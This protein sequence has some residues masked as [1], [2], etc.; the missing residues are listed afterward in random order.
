MHD[1]AWHH[2][3]GFGDSD[4]RSR[5]PGGIDR[6]RYPTPAVK[7]IADVLTA[8]FEDHDARPAIEIP[9]SAL[10]CTYGELAEG[11]ARWSAVEG[12]GERPLLVQL[13]KTM[14]YYEL[15][16]GAFLHGWSFCPLDVTYPLQRVQHIAGQLG[17]PLVIAGDPQRAAEMRAA[18]FDVVGPEARPARAPTVIPPATAPPRYYIATSGTTGVP[19]LV[20]VDHDATRP[21]LDWAL[22]FYE[23]GPHSRW[24]QIAS[25]AFDLSIVDLLVGF[26][27]GATLVAVSTLAERARLNRFSAAH[28]LTHW[29]AVPSLVPHLLRG[30]TLPDLRVVSLCG[31]P[32][33]RSTAAALRAAAPNARVVNTYG[34]TEGPLFCTFHEVTDDDLGEDRPTTIPIGRPIPGYGLRLVVDDE[35]TRLVI[36]AEQLAEGYVGVDDPAFHTVEHEGRVLPAFDTGDYVVDHGDRLCFS[37]RRDGQVKIS[38]IRVELGDVADACQRAG[39]EEAVVIAHQERLVVFHRGHDGHP[40]DVSDDRRSEL[41]ERLRE[42]LPLPVVPADFR[43]VAELPRTIS[44]KIDRRALAAR[45][46]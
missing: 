8:S 14:P 19:K 39:L 11:A 9:A 45:L 38:G 33:L 42:L 26:A 25:V 7:A 22:R 18:G 3:P 6:D 4:L 35:G 5:S 10:S 1:L 23:V 29:H 16:A 34:P 32:L 12:V 21:F 20:E 28:H 17:R 36:V 31:E 40:G 46:G 27:S 41:I 44:A 24:A 30:G 2:L 37:H 13:D 43:Y 15:A